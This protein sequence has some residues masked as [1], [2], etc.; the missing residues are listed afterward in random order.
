MSAAA[1]EKPYLNPRD[2]RAFDRQ[3]VRAMCELVN[4]YGV[5]YKISGNHVFLVAPHS[6]GQEIDERLKVSASRQPENQLKFIER[7]AE[8]FVRRAKVEEAAEVL[9]EKFNDPAKKPRVRAQAKP[10]ATTTTPEPPAP[11][12]APE[13]A[14]APAP[15]PDRT[16]PPSTDGQ[17]PEGYH[18]HIDS[19]RGIETNWWERDGGG[20]WLCKSCDFTAE[21]AS[22]RG[23]GPHQVMHLET[24]EQRSQRSRE[25]GK[26]RD[27]EA[28]AKR[29]RARNAIRWLAEEFDV[30]LADKDAGRAAREAEKL[31]RQVAKLEAQVAALTVE[32]DEA[33]AK[34]EMAKELFSL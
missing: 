31:N 6:T 29:A 23:H 14:S 17:A 32:R 27:N 9:A 21:G 2:L 11:E 1:N 18:Q 13:P 25:A 33:V 3:V 8:K 30:E 24:Q 26:S 28:A 4:T 10:V 34:L 22:L 12:P 16:E 20:K 19:R 5:E 15:G 7:W